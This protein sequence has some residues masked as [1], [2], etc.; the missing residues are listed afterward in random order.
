MADRGQG[1]VTGVEPG[2]RIIAEARL[3]GALLDGLSPEARP[4]DEAEA[5]RM[6]S[7]VHRRLSEAG[8]GRLA[9][10]KIGCT[11]PVM[12]EFL[13]IAS[14]C[15]GGVFESGVHEGE[16]TFEQRGDA[17]FGVECEVAVRLGSDLPP[18]LEPYRREEVAPAV[19]AC[20]AAIEVVE[21]RY[22][23]YSSLDTPTLI[24]DDFFA[25]ACVLGPWREGFDPQALREV[26]AAMTIDGAEAGAGTGRDL[27]GHPL[28]ALAWLA[29]N[30]SA[31]GLTL[32]A[33]ELVLLGSLV[34]TVWVQPGAVVRIGNDPLGEAVARFA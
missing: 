9:G 22:V 21:D 29:T 25:A 30:A 7:A 12:Q 10:H 23:D 6:Q 1:L 20:A 14:P 28:E 31:R 5:Y 34:A 16:A 2:A 19:A 3:A 15:A 11:T 8:R 26:H 13:G 33:G 18:R 24:A 4:R 32:R 27:M 17:R